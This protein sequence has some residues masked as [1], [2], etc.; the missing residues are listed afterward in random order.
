MRGVFGKEYTCLDG[1]SFPKLEE[2]SLVDSYLYSYE[3]INGE[4]KYENFDP[5]VRFPSVRRVAISGTEFA[6][7]NWIKTYL[8]KLTHLI[9]DMTSN[10]YFN[11]SESKQNNLEF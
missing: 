10:K 6:D 9:V 3:V 4:I 11:E 5:R 1:I 7:F 2:L 8:T